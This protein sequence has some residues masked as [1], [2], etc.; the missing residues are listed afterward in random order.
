MREYH[1]ANK[2]MT[3]EIRRFH[4]N[5]HQERGNES[6]LTFLAFINTAIHQQEFHFEKNTNQIHF[7]CSSVAIR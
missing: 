1:G 5:L 2:Q 4:V 3:H 6:R 7:Y